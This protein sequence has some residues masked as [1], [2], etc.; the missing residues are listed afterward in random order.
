MHRSPTA[1]HAR[2]A[3]AFEDWGIPTVQALRNAV[4][5]APTLPII[6]SGGLRNGLDIA[7]CLALGATLAGMAKPFL[8]AAAASAEDVIEVVQELNQQLRISL[9]CAGVSDI[10]SLQN[11]PLLRRE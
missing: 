6:A 2:I 3:A 7:K 9:F 11:T 10:A 5:G 8:E 4:S 1:S